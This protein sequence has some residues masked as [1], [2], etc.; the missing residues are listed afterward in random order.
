MSN[1]TKKF[2]PEQYDL[3]MKCSRKKNMTEWNEYREKSSDKIELEGA[4]LENANLE[5]ANLFGADLSNSNLMIANCNL[6]KL[7][8]ANLSNANLSGTDF[9]QTNLS[10]ANLKG[11]RLI[12][13]DLTSARLSHAN[14]NKANLTQAI[15]ERTNLI[16]SNLIDTNLNGA[17]LKE[18]DFREVSIGRN[19]VFGNVILS[20]IKWSTG[21]KQLAEQNNR[22]ANWRGWYKT[23][24]LLQYPTRI[25]WSLSD[26]GTSTRRIII[27]SCLL[28]LSFAFIYLIGHYCGIEMLTGF[29]TNEQS[30]GLNLTRAIYFSIV[31]MTTLGF[32]DIHA[33]PDG[34]CGHIL[35]TAQVILGY[36][37]LGAL[38]TRLSILFNSDGPSAEYSK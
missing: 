21:Y 15:L 14:L 9:R 32:G 24:N 23:H 3:L 10:K 27:T 17:N 1:D 4:D 22:R 26:Y 18:A 37:I 29:N 6:A 36:V 5:N 25:F 33:N 38:I 31:T 2:N 34:Y 16:K 30:L 12:G 7:G 19:T 35:L 8:H 13:A 11:A 20:D 28:S